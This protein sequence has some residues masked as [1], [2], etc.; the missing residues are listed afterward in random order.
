MATNFGK[1]RAVVVA[2]DDPMVQGRLQVDIPALGIQ[3]VWAAAC[4]P[5]LPVAM[6]L[7]PESGSSVWVEFEAGD[8]DLPVWTGVTWP[9]AGASPPVP[10]TM[11][12]EAPASVTVR[13]PQ[14]TLDAPLVNASGLVTCQVLNAMSSVI[15]PSYTPG[16]GNVM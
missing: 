13:A 8:E 16:A 14:V 10:G 2:H 3:G 11:T 5:P 15:S 7:W 9:A 4:L 12:I 1:H 6:L